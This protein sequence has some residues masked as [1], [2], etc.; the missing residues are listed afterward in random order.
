MRT[1]IIKTAVCV[2]A[3]TTLLSCGKEKK[4]KETTLNE[5]EQSVDKSID[6]N[7]T[8]T[9]SE[10]L[11]TNDTINAIY[12]QYLAIKAGLVNSN[13]EI[14]R[15]EAKKMETLIPNEEKYK[16]LGG[17]TKLIALNKNIDKQRDFLV[18]LTEETEKLIS[19]AAITSGEVY[20]QFCPM[21]FDGAGGYW[22]SDSKEVR[23]PYYG[24]KML[25]CG[26]VEKTIK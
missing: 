14:T 12:H 3:I 26:S 10:V 24:D 2:I 21:A 23:N 8:D 11:F 20:K 13:N 4:A 16:Q 5:M 19:D 9:K 7:K 15:A 17:V 25:T 1:T 6:I 18:T 22:L